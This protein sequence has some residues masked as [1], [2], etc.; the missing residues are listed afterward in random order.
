MTKDRIQDVAA[1]EA[2]IGRVPGPMHLKVID[3]LD[4]GAARWLA[5][6]PLMFAGFGTATGIDISVAGG[7]P[8]FAEALDAG[9]L[10]LSRAALDHPAA[11]VPGRGF[12]ALSLIPTIGES[13]RIN[14]RVRAVEP[15]AVEIEIEECYIHCAKAVIRSD[16]WAAGEE[17][18]AP[19][20]PA[21]FLE[22]CR[23]VALAT[24]DAEG[25]ADLS[26]KGDPAGAMV[27]ASGGVV[28]F[29]DRPGNR[30]ADSFR[31]VLAQPRVAM[32]ALMPGVPRVAILRGTARI[33]ADETV[34]ASFA[35]REKAPLL[36]TC[37][38]DPKVELVGSFALMRAALWPAKAPANPIDPAAILVNHVKLSKERGLPAKLLRAAV[39]IPGMM[40]RGLDRDYEK[41]LY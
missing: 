41:N 16:F 15:D 20:E 24:V 29:A 31:N 32:M 36:V 39:S 28:S 14:G 22:A 21:A 11:A 8:G 9:R 23:F 17:G 18:E 25:R 34:R 3:H 37:I 5:T 33:T 4:D 6:S 19:S 27:R 38:E 2:C 12:G 1:L 26:P 13:L 30:R 35:V 7:A 10:R 40:Q